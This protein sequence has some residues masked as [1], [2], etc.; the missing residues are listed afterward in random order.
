MTVD[1]V[2]V[3]VPPVMPTHEQADEYRTI[4]EQADAYVGTFVG[5]FV[6]AAHVPVDMPEVVAGTRALTKAGGEGVAGRGKIERA[7]FLG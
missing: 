2:N 3:V 7:R 1:G 5:A 4:P 6:L